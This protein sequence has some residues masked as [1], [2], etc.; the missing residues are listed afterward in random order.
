MINEERLERTR[1]VVA[2]E[3]PA[4]HPQIL[5][6]GCGSGIDLAYWLSAGWPPEKLAGVDLVEGRI[7]QG[8]MRCP[9]VDLRVTSG[10]SLPFA[11]GTFD[12]ATAVTVFSSILDEA[13]RQRLFAEMLRVVRPGGLILVYDFAIRKPWN[14][15][16]VAIDQRR[17]L[18]LGR[19][20][21][22]SVRLTPLLHLVALGTRF[23]KV[24]ITLAMRFAPS[25][26][27]LTLW[28][29]PDADPPS[30]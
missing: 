3:L 6:V 30:W 14:R 23:G 18:A 4:S 21:L 5:D 22:R 7:A 29:I 9:G 28:R 19:S 13:A 11:D 8:R 20:P 2:A 15:N 12:L 25:T 27:H 1:L 10:T 26:H 17:L 24:G 16:V